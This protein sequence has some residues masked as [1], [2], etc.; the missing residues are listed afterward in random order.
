[1][2]HGRNAKTR[3]HART[4]KSV[5][6]FT[7][8]PQRVKNRLF[9]E[10]ASL[11]WRVAKLEKR[12]NRLDGVAPGYYSTGID[13]TRKK[14]G[15]GKNIENWKLFNY[16]DGLVGWLE[17]VWPEIVQ[18]LLSANDPKRVAAILR[19][20]ARP[21]EIQPPWQSRCLAHPAKLFDF[22]HTRKFTRRPPKKTV[23]DALNNRRGD[24]EKRKRAANRLPTRQIANAMAGLPEIE[25]RTSLDRC[26]E[27]P[28]SYPVALNS[29]QYYRAMFG[30][31]TPETK[32]L[33]R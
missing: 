6:L 4:K 24:D 10:L 26:S 30:I 7:R 2:T 16:R 9:F 1:M 11:A 29:D 5:P 3:S 14:P 31:A 20:V 18:P 15:P 12:V 27:S 13:A 33:K 21:Q 22:L 17:E 28:C 8:F 25:W 23:T 19:K 32:K